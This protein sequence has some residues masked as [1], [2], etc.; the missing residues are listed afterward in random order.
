VA[1]AAEPVSLGHG[2]GEKIINLERGAVGSSVVV[3]F[4]S[5][6]FVAPAVPQAMEL[7][8]GA[9]VHQSERI[10]DDSAAIFRET[11]NLLNR[12]IDLAQR[13]E[14]AERGARAS[15]NESL[16]SANL[17]FEYRQDIQSLY[18]KAQS[19]LRRLD[20]LTHRLV[21]ACGWQQQAA[22]PTDAYTAEALKQ[23]IFDLEGR[24]SL[25]EERIDRLEGGDRK[26]GIIP[27]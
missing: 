8:P 14:Q 13:T 9:L 3:P 6:G 26:G 22:Q 23:E 27:S 19:S 10:R 20:L 4:M 25:L 18:D 1:L 16:Q 15:A 2:K 24:I 7:D 21:Y 12:T 17:S 5:G 11:F